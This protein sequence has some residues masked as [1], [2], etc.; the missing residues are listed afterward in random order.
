MT[1]VKIKME[2]KYKILKH[3]PSE[4]PMYIPISDNNKKFFS[5]GF[6]IKFYKSDGTEWVANFQCGLTECRYVYEFEEFNRI[7]V[8]ADGSG[9]LINPDTQKPIK[10]FGAF[11]NQVIPFRKKQLI[12]VDSCGVMLMD[13]TGVI[14]KSPRLSWDGIED[15]KLNGC[16]L[17]G[18]SFN[19]FHEGN[20]W[21]DFE[22]NLDSKII[23]GGSYI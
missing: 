22:I 11:T 19:P 17:S 7:V 5:E 21:S 10:C 1:L 15:L 8:F 2:P 23:T 3:L 16:I 18:K 14:W 9:Y 6:V 20:E 4:G 12:L 13:H